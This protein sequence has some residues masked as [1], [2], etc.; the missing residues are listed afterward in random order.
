MEAAVVLDLSTDAVETE[1][2]YG[3]PDMGL[4]N[5]PDSPRIK[6]ERVCARNLRRK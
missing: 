3:E 2:E 4:G 6:D 1:I 5:F